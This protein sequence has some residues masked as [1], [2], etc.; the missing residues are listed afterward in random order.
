M[1]CKTFLN[2]T[3]QCNTLTYVDR[4]NKVKNINNYQSVQAQIGIFNMPPLHYMLLFHCGD[5]IEIQWN[6]NRNKVL[7]LT[8]QEGQILDSDQED[9]RSLKIPMP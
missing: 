2:L 9:G 5:E 1:L 3:I 6:N 4:A 8:F 7:I